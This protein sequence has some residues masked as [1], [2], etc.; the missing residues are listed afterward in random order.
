MET[1]AVVIDL[2]E[3]AVVREIVQAWLSWHSQHMEVPAAELPHVR[4][5][6]IAAK[7][8]Y[9]ELRAAREVVESTRGHLA[10]LDDPEPL[11]HWIGHRH[12]LA[13]AALAAY[14]QAVS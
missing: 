10:A 1:E 5:A 9:A 2:N 6:H 4:Y 8:F 13:A 14:D 3:Q 7:V 12:K 11:P